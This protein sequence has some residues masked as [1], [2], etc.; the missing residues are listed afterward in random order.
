MGPQA[1]LGHLGEWCLR[2]EV[3]TGLGFLMRWEKYSSQ[4][5]QHVQRQEVTEC[6]WWEARGGQGNQMRLGWGAGP[7]TGI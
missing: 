6:G 7:E 5:E 2:E 3:K 1:F 4:R